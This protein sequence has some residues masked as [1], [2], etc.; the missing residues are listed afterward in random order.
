MSMR[1]KQ[2]SRHTSVQSTS[3]TTHFSG[4]KSEITPAKFLLMYQ[5]KITKRRELSSQEIR[6]KQIRS[7][8][9]AV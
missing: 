3:P 8:V 4:K 6:E 7:T 2:I 5:I 9:L 1:G